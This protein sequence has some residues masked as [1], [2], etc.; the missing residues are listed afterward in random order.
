MYKGIQLGD[1]VVE[2]VRDSFQGTS[3]VVVGFHELLLG[4]LDVTDGLVDKT[5]GRIGVPC[6]VEDGEG[7]LATGEC[8]AVGLV[9][10]MG[11]ED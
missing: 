11:K 9:S 2:V 6:R 5:N 4:V 10:G 3:Q 8:V 7:Y 1:V